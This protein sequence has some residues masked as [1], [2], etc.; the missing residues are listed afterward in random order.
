M[1]LESYFDDSCDARRD[2]YYACGGFIAGPDQWDAFVIQ[3]SHV[4]NVFGLTKPFRSTDCENGHGQFSDVIKWPKERRDKLMGRLV[5]IVRSTMLSAFASIIPINEYRA[6]FPQAGEHDAFLLALRQTIMNMA[7]VADQLQHEVNL[8]FERG[9]IN[10]LIT[11]TYDSIARWIQ[12]KPARRLREITLS[13]KELWPL[14]GADLIAREAFKHVDNLGIRPTR[15][16]IQRLV[17]RNL[18]FAVW[19]A[20]ALEYLAANGGPTNIEL[21]SKWDEIEE[22]P[23]LGPSYTA[24]GALP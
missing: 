20:P 11:Q 24:R 6:I 3:W 2:R 16:P 22:A 5:D 23:R 13:T 17:D 4:A 9:P 12:W 15:K 14:Q 8:W 19:N 10:G 7:Y 1:I 21:L 18:H